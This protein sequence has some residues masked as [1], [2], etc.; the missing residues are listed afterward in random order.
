LSR[1]RPGKPPTAEEWLYVL[2]AFLPSRS[3][4][5]AC[6]CER[7]AHSGAAVTNSAMTVAMPFSAARSSW[8]SY[9]SQSKTPGAVSMAD[10]MNQ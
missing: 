7:Q 5:R 9:S 2:C 3:S 10:H 6:A 4:K 1:Q 8:R